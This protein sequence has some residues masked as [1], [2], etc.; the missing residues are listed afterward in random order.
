M[1]P[2]MKGFYGTYGKGW[3]GSDYYIMKH[4]FEYV[5]F[6]FAKIFLGVVNLEVV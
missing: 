6:F 2:E 4:N 1:I 3:N 5:E